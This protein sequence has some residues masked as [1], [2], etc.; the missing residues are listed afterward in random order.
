MAIIDLI[1]R[2][3]M[4]QA[5]RY[6]AR[7]LDCNFDALPSCLSAALARSYIGIYESRAGWIA[8]DAT[9][10]VYSLEVMQTG[11]QEYQCNSIRAK[12]VR[13]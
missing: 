13:P 8:L 5:P 11:P 7:V 9:G 10:R 12:P 6:A 1:E 3:K 2:R 4:M